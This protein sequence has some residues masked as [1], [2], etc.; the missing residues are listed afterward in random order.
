VD[1]TSAVHPTRNADQASSTWSS[2][3]PGSTLHA[4]GAYFAG[5]EGA[6]AGGVTA[7]GGATAAGGNGAGGAVTQPA[8][9]KS[10]AAANAARAASERRSRKAM[11][12][13]L[14]E[15]LVA[16][17]I[18]VAIVWWTMGPKRRKPPR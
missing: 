16:L 13:F 3:Q 10:V 7:T 11:G 4:T 15:T 14:L 17:L 5:N 12:W 9:A 6:T 18:A 1:A 8:T 2:D